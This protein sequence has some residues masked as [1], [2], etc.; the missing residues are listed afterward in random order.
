MP[1]RV[2]RRMFLRLAGM[3][4]AGAVLA[5]CA[6]ARPEATEAP[7]AATKAPQATEAPVA[8]AAPESAP[9]EL[10]FVMNTTA[11][12]DDA[13][14]EVMDLFMEQN[15]GI[16]IVYAPVDWDQLAV[17]LPPRFAAKEPP[18]LLLCDVF[19]PWVQQGLVIDL[20]PLIER[21][22]IDLSM[23]SD[24]GAGLLG[25]DP[26]RYGLPFDFTGS[27]VCFNKALFDQYGV[28]YPEQGWTLDDFRTAAIT[29]TRDQDDK[30]PADG[31]FDPMNTKLY[32]FLLQNSFFWGAI[33]KMFGEPMWSEDWRT[34]TI[35]SPNGVE[36][37][38]YFNDLACNQHAVFGPGASAPSGDAFVS[39]MVAMSIEGEWQL[40]VY[41]D[42]TDFDWDVAAWPAG[43]RENR[44]YGCSDALGI[45]KD[46]KNIDA[47][48]EF[49][50]F[51]TFDRE[52][53]MMTG[54]I[55]PAALNEAGLDE[56]QLEAR[57]GERGPSL[58]NLIWAY[59]NMRMHGDGAVYYQ[60]INAEEWQPIFSEMLTSALTLCD[61][62]AEM[63]AVDT[64]ARITEILQKP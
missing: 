37:L 24:L 9:V 28:S 45:A 51:W 14:N 54:S 46:S 3:G 42:I 64:A 19:W 56:G 62:P 60:G 58:E 40:A 36:A 4:T 32:G 29:L 57:V 50:K 5:A 18:D 13:V 26:A 61:E 6:P 52:A 20:N 34:C 47:A 41:K 43:P 21:D 23:I 22:Q 7:P 30:S 44:Q 12:W 63:L 49:Q 38:A 8:S 11:E 55:M 27:V 10:E 48:W 31:D 15:P 35:D 2:S 17:V 25:G 53:A 39:Q 1:E 59:T 33:Y 16:T